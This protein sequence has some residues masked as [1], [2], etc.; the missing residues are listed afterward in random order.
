MTVLRKARAAAGLEASLDDL[1]ANVGR[2]WH[3][4]VLRLWEAISG[5]DIT[6]I[7][8]KEKMG[9]LRVFVDGPDRAGLWPL[10]YDLEVASRHTCMD[11]GATADEVQIVRSTTSWKRALCSQCADTHHE[12]QRP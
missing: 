7:S 1:Q 4:L 3:G 12:S 11:C 2:G 5:L 8:V 6:Y 10:I 9:S